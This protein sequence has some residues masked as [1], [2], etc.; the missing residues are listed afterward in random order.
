MA[1]LKS[2]ENSAWHLLKTKDVG[3]D[4]DINMLYFK[5]YKSNYI[6]IIF[7]ADSDIEVEKT[8]SNYR[9]VV[10]MSKVITSFSDNYGIVANLKIPSVM[11]GSSGAPESGTAN[12]VIATFS[13]TLETYESVQVATDFSS[14]GSMGDFR[15]IDFKVNGFI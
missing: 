15:G 11:N 9:I 2:V 13:G 14:T 12:F 10:D 7:L 4:F 5:N 6:R 8:Y 1:D 3:G